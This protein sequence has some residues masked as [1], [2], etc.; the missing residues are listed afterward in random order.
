MYITTQSRKLILRET[1]STKRRR[2]LRIKGVNFIR[3]T[4]THCYLLILSKVKTQI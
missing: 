1:Q 3:N 4:E 2:L